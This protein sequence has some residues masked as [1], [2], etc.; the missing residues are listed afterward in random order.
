PFTITV[1]DVTGA[2]IT[3]N[4]AVAVSYGDDK[5]FTITANTGYK[6]VKVLVD[7]ADKTVDMV[8][9]V[10][11]INNITSDMEI[12]V[13]V[14]K[15]V[16]EVTEGA[17]QKYTITK[18]TEAKFKINADYNLFDGKVYVDNVLVDSENYTSESGSTIITFKQSY[19][20]TLSEGEHTLKVVF[21]DGGEATTTFTIAKVAEENNG[22]VDKAE[23]TINNPKTSDNIVTFVAMFIISVLGIA[24]TVKY[25]KNKVAKKH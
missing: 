20:D 22:T 3:P 10:L 4:G 6:L 18:N 9:D 17:N 5:E 15:I 13:V 7:G 19:I 1:K 11:T 16:Y 23:N 8:G 24:I 14:E 12:E 25:N 21:T 2:T